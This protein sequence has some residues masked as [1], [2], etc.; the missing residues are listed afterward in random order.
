MSK[1]PANF[2]FVTI[3]TCLLFSSQLSIVDAA[4]L[5]I[6]PSENGVPYSYTLSLDHVN[7]LAGM[8]LSLSYPQDQLYFESATKG[9]PFKSFMHV[10]NDKNP[11]KLIVVMASAKGVSGSNLPLFVL[12]FTKRPPQKTPDSYSIKP[13]QCQLMD[14][15]L[16]EI[17]CNTPEY[18]IP[19]L[20]P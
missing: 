13:F 17:S 15:N 5:Q 2:F 19:S 14:E 1:T 20:Q 16:Q 12:N 11:G 8:K 18:A 4:E 10:V 6:T 9:K 3:L 7:K